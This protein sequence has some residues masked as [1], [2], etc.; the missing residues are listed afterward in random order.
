MP[1]D[2]R[3]PP[4]AVVADAPGRVNLIGEHTDYHEGFVL[5]TVI[6]QR[7]LVAV[8][9]RSDSVVRARSDAVPESDAVR[10]YT[11][12]HE[13]A[14]RDWL[15]YVQGVT[16]TLARHHLAVG[17]FDVH[18]ESSIP[19]GAGVSSSAAL[20]VS[21]LRAL[22]TMFDLPF[23]DLRLARLAREVET[24]FVGAPVGV[25]D[26]MASSLGRDGEALFIDTR[27]L[28]A[29]RVPI[30]PAI[31]LIVIDSAIAHA[32]AGGDYKH[33][34]EESFKAAEMLGVAMLRDIDVTAMARV[35]ALP[36]LLARRARH[37]VSENARVLAAVEALRAA[38]TA[39]LG[40]LF[41]AS[42]LSM[43]DDYEITTPAI[44]TLVSIGM[45]HPDVYAARMTGGG[46]GG[47]VVMLARAEKAME[48]ASL[49]CDT[50]RRETGNRGRVL[51]PLL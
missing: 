21:L 44:D 17:G 20:E 33:R 23:D 15:D 40:Q 32:H 30:P 11:I 39:T 9:P 13:T 10:E 19:I 35:E 26:Q 36:P 50:Y 49:V 1:V 47:S 16:S 41:A 38:D 4:H 27:T 28:Q 3:H 12:G 46:F 45:A 6:P 2:S 29:A 22:R 51:V 8:T 31:G 18:I 48:A 43:R 42:H 7:T 5:P 25:M 37:V 34:R 24:E 14:G